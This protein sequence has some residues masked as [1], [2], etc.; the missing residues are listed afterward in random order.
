MNKHKKKTVFNAKWMKEKD[1]KSWLTSCRIE[2]K[3]RCRICK[4]D[5]NFLICADKHFLVIVMKRNI[6]MLK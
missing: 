3:A 5:M 6:K 1:F 2:E 4:K